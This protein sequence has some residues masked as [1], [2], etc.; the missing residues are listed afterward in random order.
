VLIL[1]A[2][3]TPRI[4]AADALGSA[5]GTFETPWHSVENEWQRF[6]AGVYGPSRIQG[7]SFTDVI[8]LGLAPNLGDR[9]VMYVTTP[10]AHFLRA[11][12][13]D[14][15]TGVGWKSSDDRQEDKTDALNYAGRKKLEVTI[16]PVSTKGN[17][18]F[19]PSEPV[20]ASIP[21]TFIYG[22]DRGFSSQMRAKDRV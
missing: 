5:W 1:L 15:Y 20:Q 11:T 22:E 18:L 12:A 16:D 21:R 3:F 17:L 6:F 19:A 10:E 4:G 9:V 7:V 14:F 2:S 13:Y 8:R